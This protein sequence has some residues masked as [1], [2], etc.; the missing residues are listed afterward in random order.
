MKHFEPTTDEIVAPPTPPMHASRASTM[1][2][3]FAIAVFLAFRGATKCPPMPAMGDA[4]GIANIEITEDLTGAAG[5]PRIKPSKRRGK[6][7]GRVRKYGDF[8]Y[9]PD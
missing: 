2:R 1:E 9:I 7:R 8:V 4:V 3:D 6:N 5:G